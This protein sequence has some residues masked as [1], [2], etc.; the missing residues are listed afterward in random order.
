[1][2]SALCARKSNDS[3]ARNCLYSPQ[4]GT[5]LKAYIVPSAE[6]PDRL[7]KSHDQHATVFTHY[8]RN[9]YSL[10]GGT[11]LKAF[12]V[13]SAVL[14][15]RL[16]DAPAARIAYVGGGSDGSGAVPTV[17]AVVDFIGVVD[18]N[19]TAILFYVGSI[20]CRRFCHLLLAL[21]LL[22]NIHS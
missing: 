16:T 17:R 2:F 12:V 3:N 1:V 14:P 19:A 8:T 22:R 10:Q 15:D 9:F 11:G 20:T 6:L 18:I 5:G 21:L 13:P 4:G 7:T